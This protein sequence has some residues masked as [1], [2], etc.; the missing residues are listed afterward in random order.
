MF[1]ELDGEHCSADV[2]LTP[3]GPMC[4]AHQKQTWRSVNR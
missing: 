3:L 2:S 4:W 1:Y